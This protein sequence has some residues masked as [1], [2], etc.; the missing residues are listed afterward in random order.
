MAIER[1]LRRAFVGVSLLVLLPSGAVAQSAIAGVARDTT[2]AVL[3]G[4]TVEVAS[5]ALIEQTRSAVTDA[6]G[7]YKI[8]DLRPGTYSV[9][10]ALP[11]FST[12]KRDGV[13]LPANFTATINGE[14]RVG[15]LEAPSTATERG[16]NKGVRPANLASGM[17][18]NVPRKM[19]SGR[20]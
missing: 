5:P 1:L 4:V 2:G 18:A 9:T 11:G 6:Q 20:V 14:L 10:F 12:V 17:M 13:D 7:Q 8:I 16:A 15:S 3:P 19:L